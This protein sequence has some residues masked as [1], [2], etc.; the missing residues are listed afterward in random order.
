MKSAVSRQQEIEELK[1]IKASVSNDLRQL[2]NKRLHLQAD[3][4]NYGGK[5]DS[6][7]AEHAALDKEVNITSGVCPCMISTGKNLAL[8]LKQPMNVNS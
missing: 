6:L 1:H 2:E 4:T 5:I 7:K 8:P 3:I